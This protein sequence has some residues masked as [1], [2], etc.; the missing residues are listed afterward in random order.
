MNVDSIA[1][2]IRSHVDEIDEYMLEK[3]GFCPRQNAR[4]LMLWEAAK[5]IAGTADE[6]L[7]KEDFLIKCGFT[8]MLDLLKRSQQKEKVAHG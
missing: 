4:Y 1:S 2:A 3:P 7:D 5:T 8:P 6:G